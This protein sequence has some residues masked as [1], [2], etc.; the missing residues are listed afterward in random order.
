[1]RCGE[2]ALQRQFAAH[3]Y[4][5]TFLRSRPC[6]LAMLHV[7][8]GKPASERIAGLRGDCALDVPTRPPT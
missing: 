5:V 7:I 6:I 1:M 3:P 2:T 8:Y 4:A